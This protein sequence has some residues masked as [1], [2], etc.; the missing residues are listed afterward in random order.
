VPL[1]NHKPNN[2][3]E[4][5]NNFEQLA[6]DYLIQKKVKIIATNYLC[7]MGEIDIIARDQQDLVFVE[8]RYRKSNTYGGS[9]E[10]VNKGKQRRVS[11][12]A[13]HY[14]QNHQLTNKISC[15]FDVIA[16]TGTLEKININWI[17]AAFNAN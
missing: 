11:L 4:L 1:F 16:M 17:K 7:K 2:K 13:S 8:V 3:R 10:S 9:L 6:V 14:L 12:A 5:G 15:R